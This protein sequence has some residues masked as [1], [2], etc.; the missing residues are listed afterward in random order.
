[1]PLFYF[2]VHDGDELAVDNIGTDL[3]DID[4]ARIEA[5]K[6]L[7]D[8]AAEEIPRDGPRREFCI[9]VRDERK[10]VLLELRLTFN[11]RST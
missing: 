1:M 3:P 8:I 2:D 5:T 11:A 7:S 10:N 6:T 4:V 9:I